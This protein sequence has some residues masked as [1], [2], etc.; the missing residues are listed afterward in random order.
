MLPGTPT[1]EQIVSE[2]KSYFEA[3]EE[4]DAAWRKGNND[5]LRWKLS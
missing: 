4:A 3:L 2:R 5:S 1:S